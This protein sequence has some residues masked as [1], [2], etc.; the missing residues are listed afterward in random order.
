MQ[1]IKIHF[2]NIVVLRIVENLFEFRYRELEC[3]FYRLHL[4]IHNITIEINY[5]LIITEKAFSR[6]MVVKSLLTNRIFWIFSLF[7]IQL[8]AKTIKLLFSW[9]HAHCFL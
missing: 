7:S 2:R 8:G 6:H 5:I 4:K 9:R 3:Y 1:Q